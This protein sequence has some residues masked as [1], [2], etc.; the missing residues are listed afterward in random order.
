ML[1]CCCLVPVWQ[2]E[3][4][5]ASCK[6]FF[7]IGVSSKLQNK[8][9]SHG[10]GTVFVSSSCFLLL[11]LCLLICS[12]SGVGGKVSHC[13]LMEDVCTAGN[14]ASGEK[15]PPLSLLPEFLISLHTFDICVAKVNPNIRDE[16]NNLF[17]YRNLNNCM[18]KDENVLPSYSH[19]TYCLHLTCLEAAMNILIPFEIAGCD[20]SSWEKLWEL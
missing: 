9:K 7:F 5:P 1:S 6:P 20:D 11:T 19:E 13:F 10:E 8:P 16:W 14:S 3:S 17:C 15:N 12:Y 2:V 18:W 4:L